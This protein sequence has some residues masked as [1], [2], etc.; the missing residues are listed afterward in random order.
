VDENGCIV[1]NTDEK[2]AEGRPVHD[3]QPLRRRRG[4]AGLTYNQAAALE[5]F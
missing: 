5:I 4:P 1:M 2:Y 3:G